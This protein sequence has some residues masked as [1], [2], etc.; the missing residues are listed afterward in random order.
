MTSGPLGDP[1][2][3]D[4]AAQRRA[5]AVHASA[6]GI[7][8]A[9]VP[10]TVIYA[11]Q[12]LA[13]LLPRDSGTAALVYASPFVTTILLL[14]ARQFLVRVGALLALLALLIPST[15][16]VAFGVGGPL[17]L[18]LSLATYSSLYPLLLAPTAARDQQR[19]RVWEFL[20]R[21]TAVTVVIIGVAQLV[22]RGFPLRLPYFDYSPDVFEGPYGAGGHRLVPIVVAPALFLEVLRVTTGSARF[23]RSLPL[24]G[25]L[26]FGLVAPGANAMILAVGVAVAAQVVTVL[27]R[28]VARTL[29]LGGYLLSHKSLLQAL[30][31]AVLVMMLAGGVFVLTG[32]GSLPH[33]RKSIENLVAVGDGPGPRNA[34]VTAAVDTLF[35]LPARE[36]LQPALG[37]GLG[38]YSSWSQLLLS[39][40]Y[41]DRF[42]SGR[43]AGLPVSY[44][45]TAWDLILWH[46]S[47]EAYALYGRWYVESISTQPWSS[48]QSLYAETGLL[49]LILIVAAFAPLL[50][51]LR[52]GQGDSPRLVAVKYTLGTS[53]WFVVVCGFIDNFFEYPWLLVP[54]LLGLVVI[55][56]PEADIPP[57]GSSA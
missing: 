23:H 45:E 38:N 53:V 7:R 34:K 8:S 27:S 31:V 21:A 10:F 16:F 18:V 57:A 14:L 30:G 19:L 40:V 33:V 17:N 5:L 35:E 29:D 46:I 47:P 37:V 11:V 54:V 56:R 42:L 26:A 6:G 44:D 20:L 43:I 41:V 2:R 3:S 55:P 1:V 24:I 4:K 36:P 39:G 25:L 49:G 9:L 50:R 51:R 15:V 28:R 22:S 13:L 52:I 48:W 32:T 12:F